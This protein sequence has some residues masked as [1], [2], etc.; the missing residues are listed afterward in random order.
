MNA[1]SPSFSTDFD[2]VCYTMVEQAW[3]TETSTQNFEILLHYI[4]YGN[5]CKCIPKITKIASSPS[6]LDRLSICL[7]CLIGLG[8]GLLVH[9]IYG[10]H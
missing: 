8:E 1:S 9:K 5:L 3:Y 10:I 6:F 7:F 2:L 4:H